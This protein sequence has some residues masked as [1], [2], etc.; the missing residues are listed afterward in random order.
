MKSLTH[1]L[2]VCVLL[3]AAAPLSGCLEWWPEIGIPA[4]AEPWA[5]LNPAQELFYSMHDMPAIEDQ[6]KGMRYP[7]PGTVPVN[8]R[9]YPYGATEITKASAIGNPV[10]VN[11]HTL[12]YGKQMY[13][14]TC[15][16]CHGNAGRGA[17]YI[18]PP[19]PQPP[20]LTS[21]RVANMSDGELYH[22]ITHG[23]GRMWSYKSQLTEME[24]WS[25]V[26]YIRVLRR[27]AYPA[28]RDLERVS[29]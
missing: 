26:N 21:S 1:K 7:P 9:E 28:P 14:T 11:E 20:D 24:R 4:G 27:A 17:G 18:V 25:V 6:E 23:Q 22:I 12:K 3:V 13:E 8:H 16:V 19:F 29:D 2:A 10:P 15:V 5:E